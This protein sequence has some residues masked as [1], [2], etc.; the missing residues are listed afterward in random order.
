MLYTILCYNSEEVVGAWTKEQDDAVMARLT[1]VQEE[2]AAE[3]KLGPV[4]RLEQTKT[5]AT[6][7]K[8]TSSVTDGPFAEAKEQLL[9]FYVVDCA[10]VDEA[11]D[12]ARRLT[13]ANPGEGAYEVRP[14][15]LYFPAPT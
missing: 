5:A 10:S 15:Q 12:I 3:G 9:G 4:V 13:E 14:I 2:L 7:R 6:L 11:L 8:R 1:V